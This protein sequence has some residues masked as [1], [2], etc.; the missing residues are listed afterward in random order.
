MCTNAGEQIKHSATLKTSQM[1]NTWE[2]K[3]NEV[4]VQPVLGKLDEKMKDA[5]KKI[6]NDSKQGVYTHAL[7][8][9][10]LIIVGI[11]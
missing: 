1:R 9:H 5:M 6:L 11:C 8:V 10:A 3:F 4:Y 2:S 7:L